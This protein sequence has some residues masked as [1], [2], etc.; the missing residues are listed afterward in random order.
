MDF[1]PSAPPTQISLEILY[2]SFNS[3][4]NIHSVY[5][6]KREKKKFFYVHTESIGFNFDQWN[7]QTKSDVSLV[8][9][10][11]NNSFFDSKKENQ[12][13]KTNLKNNI[14]LFISL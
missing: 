2:C 7:K 6:K 12:D 3:N 9:I 13:F 1:I 4:R 11:Y 14:I 8:K 10:F 5:W